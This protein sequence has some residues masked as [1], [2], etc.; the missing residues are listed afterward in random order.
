MI[1]TDLDIAIK[2]MLHRYQL[3]MDTST[4]AIGNGCN[5]AMVVA[6]RYNFSYFLAARSKKSKFPVKIGCF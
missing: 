6:G 1:S 5:A 3:T 2:Y 4:D